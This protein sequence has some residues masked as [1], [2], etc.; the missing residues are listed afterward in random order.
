MEYWELREEKDKAYLVVYGFKMSSGIE[1]KTQIVAKCNSFDSLEEAYAFANMYEVS[2]VLE[3]FKDDFLVKEFVSR[4]YRKKWN[5]Q[6]CVY[7]FKDLLKEEY[8]FLTDIYS[9]MFLVAKYDLKERPHNFLSANQNYYLKQVY[10]PK[11]YDRLC[12]EQ[13]YKRIGYVDF[14]RGIYR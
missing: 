13:G 2:E 12:K 5:N 3:W 11:L 14:E 10:S 6:D 9:L 4:Y 8:Q 7:L 1:N